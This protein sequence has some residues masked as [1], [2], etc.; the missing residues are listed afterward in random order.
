MVDTASAGSTS[1]KATQKISALFTVTSSAFAGGYGIYSDTGFSLN[2]SV[3]VNA[4]TG[5][6]FVNGPLQC[7]SGTVN[8]PRCV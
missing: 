8:G 2:N 4:N 7:N 3:S 6:V 5:T 1:R